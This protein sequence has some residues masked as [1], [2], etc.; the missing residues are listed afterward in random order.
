MT[1]TTIPLCVPYWDEREAIAQGAKYTKELG[2]YIPADAY[3]DDV[4]NWL[5]RKWR[6]PDTPQ[7]LPEM[8]PP[9]TWED[10]VRT[11]LPQAKW[12]A[13]RRYCY[14]A[15]GYRCEVCGVGGQVECHE[16]WQFDDTWAVQHLT[17]LLCLCP[18]CHKSKHWGFAK[19]LGVLEEVKTKMCWVNGWTRRQLDQAERV[20]IAQCEERSQYHW[21]VDM[22]WLTEGRYH[23]VYRLDGNS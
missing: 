15:N 9:S 3:L 20:A 12:D 4:W 16:N 1:A 5:P 17:G 10:N 11:A 22:S 19:R 8:L 23:L 2:F 21:T 14:R 7:L 18:L 6:Y 13:L